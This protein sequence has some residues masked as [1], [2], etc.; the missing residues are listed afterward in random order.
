M[1]VR[2]VIPRGQQYD[3][4]IAV[5]FHKAPSWTFTP[6]N[7][8]IGNVKYNTLIS[9]PSKSQHKRA[10]TPEWKRERLGVSNRASDSEEYVLDRV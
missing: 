8:Q 1:L 4:N 5:V 10:K 2:K 7:R 9:E 3:A 6:H